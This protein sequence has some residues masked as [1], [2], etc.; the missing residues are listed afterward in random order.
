SPILYTIFE[1]SPIFESELY[2]RHNLRQKIW[3]NTDSDRTG[4]LKIAFDEDLSYEKY[5]DF[6]LNTTPIFLEKDGV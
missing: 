1:N 5:A 6:I 4:V 2:E 3:E